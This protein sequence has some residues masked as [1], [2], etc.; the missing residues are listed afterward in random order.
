MLHYVY[1]ITM[2]QVK[3]KTP[4]MHLWSSELLTPN[5]GVPAPRPRITQRAEQWGRAKRS[6]PL[7]WPNRSE[8]SK[9]TPG[10]AK[11]Q[12]RL[13]CSTSSGCK[14]RTCVRALTGKGSGYGSNLGTP[15]NSERSSR[16]WSAGPRHKPRFP[17]VTRNQG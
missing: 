9:S 14:E 2:F 15:S 17:V 3:R 16:R 6:S 7:R 10:S 1:S 5:A 11:P 12:T 4:P 13:A 8:S